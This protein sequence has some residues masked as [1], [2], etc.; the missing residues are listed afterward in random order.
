[1]GYRNYPPQDGPFSSCLETW[2]PKNVE[3]PLQRRP[4]QVP[5]IK[6][7]IS[8]PIKGALIF[9]PG[10][11]R[12]SSS[13]KGELLRSQLCKAPR[14]GNAVKVGGWQTGWLINLFFWGLE[15]H[16]FSQGFFI[17]I[18]KTHGIFSSFDFFEKLCRYFQ[19]KKSACSNEICFFL[20]HDFVDIFRCSIGILRV[21]ENQHLRVKS[22]GKIQSV[23]ALFSCRFYLVMIQ[24]QIV[25]RNLK[26][27]SNLFRQMKH[28][29]TCRYSQI[30]V[31]IC[32]S[33]NFILFPASFFRCLVAALQPS[34]DFAPVKPF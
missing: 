8:S 27:Y 12:F 31:Y 17:L 24:Q 25:K 29:K 30:L 32:R 18:R 23:Q 20:L 34:T 21:P 16:L 10:W 26:R 19:Q 22:M 6:P 7:Q 1:M 13:K 2:R 5:R 4:L 15:N 11:W 9:P 3:K 28:V 33:F 14:G